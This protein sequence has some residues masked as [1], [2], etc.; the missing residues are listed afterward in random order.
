[1]RVYNRAMGG[2][3]RA[4]VE[5]YL[6]AGNALGYN[7]NWQYRHTGGELLMMGASGEPSGYYPMDSNGLSVQSALPA[8]CACPVIA[9]VSGTVC[10]PLGYGGCEGDEECF[11]WGC[12]YPTVP[13]SWIENCHN[14]CAPLRQVPF[15]NIAYIVCMQSCISSWQPPRPLPPDYP[16]FVPA[17]PHAQ[18][19]IG[20]LP[21]GKCVTD[22]DICIRLAGNAP[23][24]NRNAACHAC[25]KM[26]K[27]APAQPPWG[28]RCHR[29]CDK[30]FP[31]Y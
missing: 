29:Q 15:G 12:L 8:P 10:P 25:C 7:Q 3:N 4:S 30:I 16:W 28:S 22:P 26:I 2:T 9:P 31:K 20:H 21:G 13:P 19:C 23:H 6:P 27:W 24:H 11:R 14:L 5:D 1:M 18:G 17:A